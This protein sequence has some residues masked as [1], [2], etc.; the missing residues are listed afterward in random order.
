[1]SDSKGGIY[2]PE[3]L[4]PV[5]VEAYKEEH[6]SLKG[7]PGAREIINSELLELPVDVLVPAALE[8]QLT[9]DNASRVQAKMVLELANGPTTPEADLI[10]HTAGI[11]VV[12]DILANAGGVVVSTFEWQQNRQ[13]ERWTEEEVLKKLKETLVPQAEVIWGKSQEK[14]IT[15]RTAAYLL[16][17]ERLS[18]EVS[19]GE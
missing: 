16:A 13:G 11:K 1:M 8:N 10:L 6:R 3:G 19:K 18:N 2:N 12:P 14:D 15:L 9:E 17:L 7:F 5:A 4:D